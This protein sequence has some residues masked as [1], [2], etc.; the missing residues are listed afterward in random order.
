MA[1]VACHGVKCPKQ[2]PLGAEGDELG[3]VVDTK[4]IC[5]IHTPHIV[6]VVINAIRDWHVL[7]PIIAQ[8]LSGTLALV[9]FGLGRFLCLSG[10]QVH[11]QCSLLALA[12][13]RQQCLT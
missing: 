12:Q 2:R 13:C 4:L 6:I 11:K 5:N 8:G 7:P 1:L 3:A 10:L 9:H